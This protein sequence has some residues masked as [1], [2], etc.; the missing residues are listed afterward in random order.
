MI[1]TLE[2]E[3][4]HSKRRYPA[5]LAKTPQKTIASRALELTRVSQVGWI[6]VSK[7]AKGRKVAVASR[8]E[9]LLTVKGVYL[10]KSS[11]EP[12]TKTVLSTT[13][14]SMKVVPRM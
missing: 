2:R 11:F 4:S 7:R 9:K 3:S 12:T 13:A 14:I 8:K 1:S 10:A 5:K 6:R